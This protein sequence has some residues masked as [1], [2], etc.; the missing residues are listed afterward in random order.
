MCT[1]SS[2]HMHLLMNTWAD[3]LTWLLEIV[4]NKHGHTGISS[5]PLGEFPGV[6]QLDQMSLYF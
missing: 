5:M 1:T 2:L 3:S 4:C 6:G